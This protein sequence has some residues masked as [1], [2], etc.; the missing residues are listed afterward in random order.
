MNHQAGADIVLVGG[1]HAH[2]QVLRAFAMRPEPG[3][4]LTLIAR[5]LATVYSGMLPGVVAGLYTPEQAHIDLVRLA[6][7]CGARLIHA[8]AVGLD[9]AHKRVSL[10]NRPPIAYDVVSI[11]VGITPALMPIAGAGEHA[12]AVKPIGHFMR[13][14]DALLA[15][16]RSSNG[17]RRIGVIGGGAGGV[18]LLLSVRARF[19]KDLDL[20][21]RRATAPSFVLVTAGEILETHNRRVRDAFRHLLHR[22]GIELHE[23]RRALAVTAD[24]IE[25]EGGSTVKADVVLVATDAAAPSWFGQTGLL[26]APGGFIAVDDTLQ[27][28]NDPDVFAAGDCAAMIATPREKA[29][30]FAVRSGPPLAENLR[31]RACGRPPT[32]WR[33]QRR[34]L[35]LISTGERHAVASRA[36]FKAEGAWVWRLKDFID[37]RWMRMYQDV[38]AMAARRPRR[39]RWPT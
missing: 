3:V 2:V 30:V 9:R 39:S 20:S 21:G 36:W 19:L 6:A 24:A 35:T 18:E 27:T 32:A 28:L 15:R 34:H 37:R 29:G 4:R 14:F 17:A 25:L 11:D 22:R 33:P 7:A 38:D 5:E 1:G 26:L 31:Q 10:A 8:E 16:C 23:H 12:I 13:E